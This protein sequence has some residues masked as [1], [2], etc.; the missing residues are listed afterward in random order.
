MTQFL[1]RISFLKF[2]FGSNVNTVIECIIIVRSDSR[3]MTR[4]TMSLFGIRFRPSTTDVLLRTE[5]CQYLRSI[6]LVLICLLGKRNIYVIHRAYPNLRLIFWKTILLS[7]VRGNGRLQA[8][9][10][11]LLCPKSISL[12]FFSS[13]FELNDLKSNQIVISGNPLR[14][15]RFFSFTNLEH[16]SWFLF[17]SIRV[18]F[19]WLCGRGLSELLCQSCFA[20]VSQIC[21]FDESILFI[22][23][24]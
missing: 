15:F 11:V 9:Y 14:V 24:E 1:L 7:L 2:H 21:R 23:F 6:L 16:V 10:P 4:Y 20:C 17:H 3:P 19:I 18:S 12:F 8:P 5:G 22:V 13:H